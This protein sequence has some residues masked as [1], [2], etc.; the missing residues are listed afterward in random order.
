MLVIPGGK[1]HELDVVRRETR[2]VS[3]NPC[4]RFQPRCRDCTVVGDF[5]DHA[6]RVALTERRQHA[7]TDIGCHG[8][9]AT[10]IKQRVER[11]VETDAD[12]FH[13]VAE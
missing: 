2:R 11:H 9:V 12:N 5:Q 6:Q 3:Q 8:G 4:H 13:G 10:V 1:A 7:R